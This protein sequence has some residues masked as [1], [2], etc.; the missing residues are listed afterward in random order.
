[1]ISH[2]L[3]NVI[4]WRKSDYDG[5]NDYYVDNPKNISRDELEELQ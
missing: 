5:Y 1:M 4:G 3:E 2:I